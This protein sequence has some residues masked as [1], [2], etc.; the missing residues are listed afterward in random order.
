MKPNYNKEDLFHNLPDYISREIKNNE[1]INEIKN[2]IEINPEFKDEYEDMKN[3]FRFI[4]S[5]ELEEPNENYFNNLSVRINERILKER[6]ETIW[7]KIGLFWKILIPAVSIIIIAILLFN[8]SKN[9]TINNRVSDNT[10]KK[11]EPP[12]K[13]EVPQLNKKG[14]TQNENYV[15]SEKQN[16]DLQNTG[17]KNHSRERSRKNT[18]VV[19]EKPVF[20]SF[21]DNIND[22]KN[23][24][25]PFKTNSIVEY[26]DDNTSI[27]QEDDV[28]YI[29]DSE[30]EDYKDE[31]LDLTPAEQNEILE[32]L[33]NSQ[34]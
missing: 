7:E 32:N 13:T 21:T 16:P 23:Y 3:T 26:A 1:L 9:N 34:I 22:E 12:E 11:V 24:E 30:Y 27:E 28:M 25:I 15:I 14:P 33:S 8:Y 5:A 20:E 2:E 10:I 6:D 29:R 4:D 19:N 31:F 18:G 17:K